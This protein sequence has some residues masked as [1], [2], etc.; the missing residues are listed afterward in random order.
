MGIIVRLLISALAV[1]AGAY[2]LPGV[3]VRNFTTAII[4]AII[5]ALLNAFLKP[6]LVILTIPVTVITLGLFLLVINAVIILL[7]AKLVDGFRVDGFWYAMLFSVVLSLI[8]A[9]LGGMD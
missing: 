5:L 6:V 4:V 2:I 1:F 8:N 9:V 3:H 7:C